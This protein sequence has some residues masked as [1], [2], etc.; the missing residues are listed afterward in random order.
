MNS[1]LVDSNTPIRG[2]E[3][4]ASPPQIRKAPWYREPWAWFVLSP[5]IAVLLVCSVLVTLAVY[6]GDD[7]VSDDYYKEG[8]M[9]N[10]R[11]AAEAYAKSNNINGQL[12]LNNT[13]RGVQLT[14]QSDVELGSELVLVLS[15]P[16]EADLDQT[17]VLR[18]REP[19]LYQV[20]FDQL[21]TGRRYIRVESR[22]H[23]SAA[24]DTAMPQPH[25]RITGEINFEKDLIVFLK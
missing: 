11:F 10:N 1:T 9:V 25:W 21:L 15:H 5:L 20:E 14:M 8:K 4:K 2:G 3:D 17:L 12:V 23:A 13:G 24:A 18:L 22:A 6:G 7:V 16:A 19:N